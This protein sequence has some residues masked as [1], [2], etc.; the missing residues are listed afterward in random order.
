MNWTPPDDPE[1]EARDRVKIMVGDTDANE[2]LLADEWYDAQLAAAAPDEREI[3]YLAC[4]AIAAHYARQVATAVGPLKEEA[5]RKWE[6]YMGQ[7]NLM[8]NIW[9][10]L[11]PSANGGGGI[12][13]MGNALVGWRSAQSTYPDPFF[14]RIK[15]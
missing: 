5:Q 3:A 1:N 12:F 11:A 6:H 14:T 2:E 4:V 8:Y 15:P 13:N 7:T 9:Q 10:G